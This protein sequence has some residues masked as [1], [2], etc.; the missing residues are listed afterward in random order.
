MTS[1]ATER[2]RR[3]EGGFTLVELMVVVAIIGVLTGIAVYYES[4][5]KRGRAVEM[6]ARKIAT[7]FEMARE[8]AIATQKRQRLIIEESLVS[9]W[10][11][12]ATGLGEAPDYVFIAEFGFP[13][14][15]VV[16]ATDAS[17]H[18]DAETSLPSSG[19]DVPLEIDLLPDGRARSATATEFFE[20]GWTVFVG[21]DN[22]VRARAVLFGMTGTSEVFTDW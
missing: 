6:T 9:H 16:D 15:T 19:D 17:I 20:S 18:L 3:Q 21:D 1:S 13:Q 4:S 22:D 11:S 2:R 10:E 12:T 8:R 5:G 7:Q 14:D